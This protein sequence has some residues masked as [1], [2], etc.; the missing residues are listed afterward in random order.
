MAIAWIVLVFPI[1]LLVAG[2]IRL[3]ETGM[4]I[5]PPE[6]AE[7]AALVGIV[8]AV[9]SALHVIA[10]GPTTS[11]VFGIGH[12]GLSVLLDAVSVILLLLKSYLAWVILRFSATYLQG[13]AGEGSFTFRL[14]VTLAGLVLL[15]TAGNLVQ[16]GLG[17]VAITVGVN[18]LLIF[19]PQRLG[20]LRASRKK[21]LFSRAADV[22][23]TAGL[24]LLYFAYG[25]SDIAGI[26]EAARA[27]DI[28]VTALLAAL[29]LAVAAIL[30]SALLP[31]HGWLIETL[32]TPTPA[33]ALIHAG[34]VS[35]GGF[36]LIR[37]ADVMLSAPFILAILV[38]VG[39]VSALVGSVVM[40]TQSAAKTALAWST[41]S[42]MGFVV[43]LCGLGLF[44]LALLHIT[45]HALYK[46]HAFL[47]AADAGQAIRATQ[48]LGPIARTSARYVAWAMGLAIATYALI[49]L[50]LGFVE[51]SPQSVAV[52]AI[53]VLGVGYLVAQG[54]A[55]GAP[56]KLGMATARAS[57]LFAVTY[58]TLQ[59]VAQKL[60]VGILPPTPPAGPLEWMLIVLV[61]LSFAVVAVVQALLPHW[62]T[63]PV[64]R[65]LRVHATNGFYLNALTDRYTGNW[66]ADPANKET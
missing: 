36:L 66:K 61:F 39:G 6:W 56:R 33:S 14:C 23:L 54:F 43:L 12:F 34:V 47:T 44:P 7:R 41:V 58:F 15:V 38:V 5:E 28:P 4:P 19:Y 65:G 21:I 55:D 16:L 11:P 52:G 18:R 25:V 1:G 46:V 30:Q 60:T 32:E 2:A 13:E 3:R 51:K 62:S 8:L 63:C 10:F 24:L 59:W 27:G 9:Y 45:A 22:A 37:F 20:A 48:Q 40:L 26:N 31:V 64:I 50:T 49:G 35:A 42:Q 57:A 29:C 17:W 53:L